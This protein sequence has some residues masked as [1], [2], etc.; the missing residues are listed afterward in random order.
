MPADEPEVHAA[1]PE[2]ATPTGD[3]TGNAAPDDVFAVGERLA[4]EVLAAASAIGEVSPTAAHRVEETAG[5]IADGAVRARRAAAGASR[6]GRAIFG[7]AQE[8]KVRG[9][10]P[11]ERIVEKL[12]KT[13]PL[14]PFPSE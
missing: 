10:A 5:K 4:E 1:I 14:P 11:L 6:I 9:G 13:D 2:P 3:T 8:V 7:A 12:W